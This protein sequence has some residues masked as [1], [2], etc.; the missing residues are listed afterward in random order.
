[1]PSDVA[2]SHSLNSLML[3]E[4]C[5]GCVIGFRRIAGTSADHTSSAP[6]ASVPGS[7]PGRSSDGSSDG[8]S[9]TGGDATCAFR[10]PFGRAPHGTQT[11][12]TI[13]KELHALKTSGTPAHATSPSLSVVCPVHTDHSL[14][15]RVLQVRADDA[16]QCVHC[17]C[18]SIRSA[19]SAS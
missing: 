18:R 15:L 16:S 5:Q 12:R 17:A 1:M 11:Y 10:D 2:A 14:L 19:R 8:S 9:A 4:R 7:T 13:D 3:L 6:P